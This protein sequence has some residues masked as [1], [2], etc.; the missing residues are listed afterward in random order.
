MPGNGLTLTELPAPDSNLN[1]YALP[2]GQGDCTI[3]QC[4][5]R[6][7][8]QHLTGHNYN[9]RPSFRTQM[10][11][12]MPTLLTVVDMGSSSRSRTDG[13]MH[14]DD[15]SDFLGNQKKYIEVVAISHRDADHHN[16]I[17]TVLPLSELS[18]FILTDV[19]KI[20][21]A[22]LT[23]IYQLLMVGYRP[24]RTPASCLLVVTVARLAVE[25]SKYVGAWQF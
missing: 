3:I 4:P 19:R 2:V 24:L 17:P 12:Q 10:P 7:A 22:V 5:A 25:S 8:T 15:V 16:Y 18:V 11:T 6:S 21:T 14:E 20:S 13:H 9:L 23:T 1:V